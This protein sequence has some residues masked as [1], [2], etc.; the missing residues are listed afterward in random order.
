MKSV[1]L[2]GSPPMPTQVDWPM[3]EAGELTDRLV[4]ER[5]RAG[6]DAD[7]AGLVDVPGHDADL[8][9]AGGDDAG[10]VGADEACLAAVPG[11]A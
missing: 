2:T 8:A 7:V 5:A 11:R 1:P 3:P 9:L 10:A 6:D 4:G